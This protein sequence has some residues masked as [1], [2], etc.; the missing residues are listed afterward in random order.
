MPPIAEARAVEPHLVQFYE[1]DTFLA[2][3]VADFLLEGALKGEPMLLVVTPEHRQPFVDRLAAASVDA[4]AAMASG[5]L[6]VLDA[7]ETL[8]T[9]MGE[10]GPDALRFERNVGERIAE[11]AARHPGK[12]LRVF[13]E[14]VDLLWREGKEAAAV[15]LE[16]LWNVLQ[17]RHAFS[18][19]CAYVIG[20]FLKAGDQHRVEHVHSHVL[21]AEVAGPGL[22]QRL[23][24]EIVQRR[25]IEWALRDA[26]NK[27]QTAEATAR[28]SERRLKDITDAVPVLVSY[29]DRDHCYRFVNRKYGEWF[30]VEPDA[31]VGRHAREVLGDDM[32][33]VVAPKL[34]E[35]L[36]GK[37]VSYQTLAKYRHGPA[38]EIEATYIPHRGE[39]GAIIGIAAMVRDI[40]E[41]LERQAAERAAARRSERLSRITG[42]IAAAVTP[43]QVYDAM[44]DQ[45]SEALGASA[46]ALWLL[47]ED[48]R[49]RL[50]KAKGYSDAA[51]RRF[52]D[53]AMDDPLRVP[54]LDVLRDADLLWFPTV[55]TLVARYPHLSGATTPGVTSS[56]ACM[57]LVVQGRPMGALGLSF[58]GSASGAEEDRSFLQLVAQY[59][60]Q[61]LER[62]RLLSAEKQA[63]A[64]AELLF[65][66]A[67]TVMRASTTD[68]IFPATLEAI[69]RTL[70]AKRSAILVYDESGVMRFRAFR[71]LSDGY[72]KAVE[73]HSPWPRDATDPQVVW[74]G[75]AMNDPALASYRELFASERIGALGFIPL[76][77]SGRLLGKFMVYYEQ[78]KV[79]GPHELDLAGA[80]ANHIAAA[81]ARFQAVSE[82]QRTVRFSEMF[83]AILGHDLRNPLGAIMTASQLLM[84]RAENEKLIRPLSRIMSSGDRMARMI[85]QLLDFTRVRVG[86]G[87]PLHPQR[88][89]VRPV[90]EEVIAELDVQFPEAQLELVCQGDTSGVWDPD[91]LGQVFSNLVGNAIQHG[92]EHGRV[93]VR[94]D[95][96]RPGELRA[97]VHNLGAVPRERLATLFEPM[98]GSDRRGERAQGLGLGLYISKEIARAHGGSITVESS[99]AGGTRFEVALPRPATEQ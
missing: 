33:A 98:T 24:A 75:D 73:G 52:G 22:A 57:P 96:T 39:D 10:D 97:A 38:R 65:D 68:E 16:E 32:Y 36:A 81:T 3:A 93:S 15:Q 66:L 27:Q 18:L 45:V 13:G 70:G 19:F 82:L 14:M 12:R 28:L 6:T 85:D 17:Q 86:S 63:R 61:A 69:E 71:G 51:R 4:G 95:G 2:G 9:F 99:D 26:L 56:V 25:Q 74:V 7:A 5:Q 41:M 79:L 76:V 11:L 21:H 54:C 44:V 64:Q 47:G 37:T 72:R 29:I 20:N 88:I 92:K 53:L 62:L 1:T 94:I 8:R 23:D 49:V 55:E 42:A 91:R 83:T 84:R 59:G 46:C 34:D 35:A 58:A 89:D 50:V 40:G 31:L 43:Q 67:Q 90:I 48:Q 87:I 30:G 80:I 60:G 78:P 77:A